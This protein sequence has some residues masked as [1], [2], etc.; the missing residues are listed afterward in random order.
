MLLQNKYFFLIWQCIDPIFFLWFN[1][2][3]EFYKDF[4]DVLG[5]FRR[6]Q[7]SYPSYVNYQE[8]LIIIVR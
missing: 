7:N 5:E 3:S 6:P 1:V 2:L 4:I 8:A